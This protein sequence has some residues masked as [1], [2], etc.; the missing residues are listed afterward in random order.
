[1]SVPKAPLKGLLML[2]TY[3]ASISKYG[4]IPRPWG[5]EFQLMNLGEG[6]T[7]PLMGRHSPQ[8]TRLPASFLSNT[9]KY[10]KF[11]GRDNFWD[12]DNSV[13]Q[14]SL[15]LFQESG[16][17]LTTS[18][19]YGLQLSKKSRGHSVPRLVRPKLHEGI[20]WGVPEEREARGAPLRQGG[21]GFSPDWKGLVFGSR[22]Q[23]RPPG[24]CQRNNGSVS[25]G[26]GCRPED[27]L[28]W[29]MP[30]PLPTLGRRTL[31]ILRLAFPPILGDR[32]ER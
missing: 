14:I 7:Q 18:W 6:I 29:E 27:L 26:K 8:T 21:V 13:L 9:Q 30:K 19:A 11:M 1:M 31:A 24:C 5:V 12:F 20:L 32:G 25:E 15:F 28:L 23:G 10:I 2:I 4:C 17:T 3:K 22:K 16:Q